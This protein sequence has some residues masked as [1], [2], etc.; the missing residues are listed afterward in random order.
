MERNYLNQKKDTNAIE[1]YNVIR[2]AYD[3]S[4]LNENEK[5]DPFILQKQIINQ[6]RKHQN[7]IKINVYPYNNYAKLCTKTIWIY[8]QMMLY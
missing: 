8:F 1:A 6:M 3:V 2:E 5:V 4:K 7:Q